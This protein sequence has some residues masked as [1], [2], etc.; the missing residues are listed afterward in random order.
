M[1]KLL[2]NYIYSFILIGLLFSRQV[3]A[4][5]ADNYNPYAAGDG[6]QQ[7]AVWDGQ[8]RYGGINQAIP[9]LTYLGVG[10]LLLGMGTGIVSLQRERKRS[11]SE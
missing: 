9:G 3:P 2:N 4:I 8:V 6:S 11:S 1:K 5:D 7:A 10:L